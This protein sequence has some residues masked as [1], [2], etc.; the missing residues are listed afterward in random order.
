MNRYFRSAVTVRLTHRALLGKA[1]LKSPR[2]IVG[3]VVFSRN[4]L[5]ASAGNGFHVKLP[6][7]NLSFT[8]VFFMIDAVVMQ[9][10]REQY[11]DLTQRVA[12]LRRF[13]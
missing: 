11:H 6:V 13:L 10:L 3:A 7:Q 12:E 5:A 1:L 8:G 4:A 9:E 2:E